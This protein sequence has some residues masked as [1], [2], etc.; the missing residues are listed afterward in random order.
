MTLPEHPEA[1]AESHAAA[2]PTL[3]PPPRKVPMAFGLAELLPFRWW[4]VWTV[5]VVAVAPI[6]L[7]IQLPMAF[8]AVAVPTLAGIYGAQLRGSRIRIGLL[9]WGRVA[10]VTDTE[11][12]SRATYYSGTIWYN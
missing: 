6:A 10:T 4:Y 7:W 2:G 5:F 12:V 1:S 9:R 8:A 3:A 11:I